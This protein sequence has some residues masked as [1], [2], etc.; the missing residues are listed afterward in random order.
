LLDFGCGVGDFLHFAQQKGYETTGAD[1]SSDARQFASQKLGQKILSPD[2]AFALS[3][4]SFDII[5]MWHVLEHISDLKRQVAELNRLLADGGRLVI[6]LPNYQSYDAQYYKDK[7]AAYDVPR[8]LNHFSRQALEKIFSGTP[9][10]L[11]R[12]EAL[13]WD[14]YYISMMSEGYAGHSGAFL[15]GVLTGLKSNCAARKSGQYSSMVYI[16]ERA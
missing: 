10:R 5:T 12:V 16:F 14:A 13:K 3:D 9:L 2:E 15:K 4:G 7:W 8:H 6:A 11:V 1:V